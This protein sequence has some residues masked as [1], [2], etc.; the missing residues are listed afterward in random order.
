MRKSQAHLDLWCSL[1]KEMGVKVTD[2]TIWDQ[3]CIVKGCLNNKNQG[4]FIGPLC[5]PCHEMLTTGIVSRGA[6]F[7][8][9]MKKELDALKAGKSPK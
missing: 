6:N 1:Q 2:K 8:T 3:F 9:D 7:I 4:R 5:A